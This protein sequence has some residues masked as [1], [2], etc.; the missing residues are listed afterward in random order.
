MS[1]QCCTQWTIPARG[2]STPECRAVHHPERGDGRGAANLASPGAGAARDMDTCPCSDQR[3]A[4]LVAVTHNNPSTPLASSLQIVVA[5]C[6]LQP[7]S[8]TSNLTTP[9]PSPGT[10]GAHDHILKRPP[11]ICPNFTCG[12]AIALLKPI[13]ALERP[14]TP[15]HRHIN[16]HLGPLD[17]APR[18]HTYGSR[19]RLGSVHTRP[20]SPKKRPSTSTLYAA[21]LP[22]LRHRTRERNLELDAASLQLDA[23]QTCAD[24]D[25]PLGRLTLFRLPLLIIVAGRPATRDDPAAGRARPDRLQRLLHPAVQRRPRGGRLGRIV[26]LGPARLLATQQRR[27]RRRQETDRAAA[28]SRLRRARRPAH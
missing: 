15:K 5:V 24:P 19:H 2:R 13:A 22:A 25:T 23:A 17:C 18:I 1:H 6:S 21:P 7:P 26:I 8:T 3:Y 16:I 14:T 4:N 27:P 12:A 28:E 20:A 10:S 9:N 11:H